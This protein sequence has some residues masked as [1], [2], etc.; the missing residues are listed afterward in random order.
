[1]TGL[2]S[3]S[4]TTNVQTAVDTVLQTLL[5]S[6]LHIAMDE[7]DL[8]PENIQ[9]QVLTA[10]L[11]NFILNHVKIIRYYSGTAF[12]AAVCPSAKSF[13]GLWIF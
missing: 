3:I 11:E 9:V 1:M 13:A 5:D 2:G 12:G 6:D 7:V 4:R 8:I 10:N